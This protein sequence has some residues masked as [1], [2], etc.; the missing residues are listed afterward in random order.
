VAA[1]SG[2][3]APEDGAC[4]GTGMESIGTAAGRVV[5][6]LAVSALVVSQR[7]LAK[8]EFVEKRMGSTSRSDRKL[9]R[10]PISP[11]TAKGINIIGASSSQLFPFVFRKVK[12]LCYNILIIGGL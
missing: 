5:S 11:L 8:P 10:K 12:S 2:R 9:R 1:D 3:V 6:A 4:V 7:T